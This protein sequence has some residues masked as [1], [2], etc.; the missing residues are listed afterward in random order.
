[1]RVY[2]PSAKLSEEEKKE[3]VI[4]LCSREGQ[5]RE[6]AKKYGVT[7]AALY[8]WKSR[9][10]GSGSPVKRRSANG[11][12]QSSRDTNELESEEEA[13]RKGVVNLRSENDRVQIERDVLAA[14]ETILKK[15]GA[16]PSALS[17]RVK[18]LITSAPLGK[19]RLRYLLRSLGL[20]KSSYFYQKAA[21]AAP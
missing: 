4:D 13:L 21:M 11:G 14:P 1:G 6:A 20:A 19:S 7:R 16:Y 2:K 15:E 18:S 5:A 17:I 3:A 12:P 8:R 9:L 10:L